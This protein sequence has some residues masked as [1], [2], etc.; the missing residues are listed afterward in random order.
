M[1]ELMQA[2][3]LPTALGQSLRLVHR[4][5]DFATRRK[6]QISIVAQ[7]LIELM[8]FS[9]ALRAGDS[10]HQISLSSETVAATST[11][12]GMEL[13]SDAEVRRQTPSP[14]SAT[15]VGVA[16]VSCAGLH[17]V[18]L[19]LGWSLAR[20]CGVSRPE[21]IAVAF[22]GSQ[23]TLPIGIYVANNAVFATAYPFAMFPMLLFHTSQLF[24]D[25]AIASRLALR[26]EKPAAS[27]ASFTTAK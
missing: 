3:L 4:L 23:K 19:G 27:P 13:L 14:I 6:N 12:D 16:W 10:L 2:V 26:S 22:A 17:L 18:T 11:T 8:V 1:V 25:T 21:Q 24:L 20:L 15:G 7:V 9:A 5:R